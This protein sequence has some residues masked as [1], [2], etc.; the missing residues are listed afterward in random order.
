MIEINK[1]LSPKIVMNVMIFKFPFN[2]L[3]CLIDLI[4][5]VVSLVFEVVDTIEIYDLLFS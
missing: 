3:L 2:Y 5:F 4:K 1:I